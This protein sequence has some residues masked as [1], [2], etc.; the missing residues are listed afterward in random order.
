MYHTNTMYNVCIVK[1]GSDI[2]DFERETE[3]WSYVHLL[4]ICVQN[5]GVLIL[6]NIE[7]VVL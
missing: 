1:C 5:L 6:S 4:S 3:L 2:C 7:I